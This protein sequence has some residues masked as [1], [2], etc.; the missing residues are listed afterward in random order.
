VTQGKEFLRTSASVTLTVKENFYHLVTML[1]RKDFTY[2]KIR[3]G[4]RSP[5]CKDNKLTF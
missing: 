5:T 3:S 1:R 4:L 2:S